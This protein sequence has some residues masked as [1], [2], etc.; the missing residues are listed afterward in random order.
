M[1]GPVFRSE[2]LMIIDDEAEEAAAAEVVGGG[3]EEREGGWRTGP[4]SFGAYKCRYPKLIQ[5]SQEATTTKKKTE[6]QK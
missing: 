6:K 5:D 1:G 3:V 4:Q 2:S